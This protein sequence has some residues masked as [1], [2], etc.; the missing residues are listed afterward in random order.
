MLLWHINEKGSQENVIMLRKIEVELSTSVPF[1]SEGG[2]ESRN[3]Y[4]IFHET[5]FKS[6]LHELSTFTTMLSTFI[7][8]F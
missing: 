8:K 7:Y 2:E 3:F 4:C 6:P 1:F 5:F